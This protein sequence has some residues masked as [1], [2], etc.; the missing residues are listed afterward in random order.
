MPSITYH[1]ISDGKW[2][3][4]TFPDQC[5]EEIIMAGRCQ[6]VKGHKGDHWCYAND[7]SYTWHVNKS[8][9]E[10]GKYDVAAGKTPPGHENYVHPEKM[11]DKQFRSLNTVEDVTDPEL[12]VK[13]ENGDDMLDDDVSITRPVSEEDIKRFG[14]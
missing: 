3:K 6:G 4:Q 14:L 1:K 13:L 12:I 10:I 9:K 2:L 5:E 7:G 8:E 11:I